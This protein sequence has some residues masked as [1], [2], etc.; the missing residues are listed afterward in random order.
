MTLDHR[1]G[2]S[3]KLGTRRRIALELHPAA[4]QH[5]AAMSATDRAPDVV[6]HRTSAALP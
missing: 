1:T 6:I 3:E 5:A 2:N 4:A